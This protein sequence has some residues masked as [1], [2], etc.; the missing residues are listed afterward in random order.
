M[1]TLLSLG[2]GIPYALSVGELLHFLLHQNSVKAPIIYFESSAVI[3]T[4]VWLG[5]WL[6]AKARQQSGSAV[7]DL[8]DLTPSEATVVD[9]HGAEMRVTLSELQANAHVRIAPGERIPVDGI[10][11]AGISSVDE[12]MFT[13]E[14]LPV[15][16]NKHDQVSAGTINGNGSLLVEVQRIGSATRLSQIIGLVDQ[17][18]RSRVPI[19]KTADKLA[20]FFVPF[21]MVVSIGTFFVWFASG[22]ELFSAMSRAIAVLVVA[23]PCALGLATPMAIMV[24]TGRAARAGVLFKEAR[25]L[26]LLSD[27]RILVL[28]KTGTLTEGKPQ[29]AAVSP[30]GSL[31]ARQ[32]LT[33]AGAVEQ[34]SEHPLARALRA[35]CEKRGFSLPKSSDFENH[36]GSELWL[37]W[38]NSWSVSGPWRLC[39]TVP[40]MK[41]PIMMKHCW[42]LVALVMRKTVSRVMPYALLLQ[43][44]LLQVSWLQEDG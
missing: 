22:A 37:G 31:D 39:A 29:V 34:H 27:V 32:V 5:Q 16:K 30:V 11:L 28:D 21:V 26:Q 38:M 35:E 9:A 19:Q 15:S 10:V 7:K 1:F 42:S 33:L 23:C 18:Q 3:A 43:V 25:S 41:C 6:E 20:S 40:R 8:M 13:G 36:P 24:A 14:P 2:I 17:A 4:L 44:A 12:S